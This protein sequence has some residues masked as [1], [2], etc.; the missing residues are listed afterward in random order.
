MVSENALMSM[1]SAAAVLR[2]TSLISLCLLALPALGLLRQ[3]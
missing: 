2:A 1:F 3:Q